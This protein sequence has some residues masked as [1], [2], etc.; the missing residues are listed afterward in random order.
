MKHILLFT[1]L[2]TLGLSTMEGH[3]SGSYSRPPGPPPTKV[4]NAKYNLGKQVF[5]GKAA[6]ASVPGDAAT[7]SLRLK[8]LQ[9]NLPKSAKKSA[10][11]P[12]LAGKLSNEQ[13]SAIEHFLEV[14]YK[15]K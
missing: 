9:G 4:D 11:L 13:M 5:A 14:R 12:L 10:N 15:T 6:P 2:I 1:C 3:A 7:Q 8:E